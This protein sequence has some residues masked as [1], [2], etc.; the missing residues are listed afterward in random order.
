MEEKN[1]LNRKQLILIGIVILILVVI[2]ICF[3][4]ALK[5]TKSSTINSNSIGK[6]ASDISSKYSNIGYNSSTDIDEESI[7]KITDGGSYNLSGSYKNI[8]INTTKDV[9]LNLN[10]AEITCESGPAIYVENADTVSIVLIGKNIIT[11]YTTED[12][13]G[14]IYSKDDLLFSGTGS[15]EIK[16]N[17]DGIVS[18]DSL[19][20][21]SGTYIINSDDDGIRGKDNVAIVDGTFTITA[22]GDGIKSTNEKDSSKGYVAIDGGI[23]NITSVNDGIQA[24]TELV[25]KGGK[26]TIKTTNTS[27]QDSSKGLKAGNLV[28][29]NGGTFNLNTIDDGIHS[30]G[31]ITLNNGDATIISKDDGV[32]ADGLVEINNGTFDITA[33]EG[34]EGTYVKINGG[35]INISA[36]DDG[37]NAANKSNKYSVVVEISGGNIT[38]KMGTGDTDGI[39]SNGNLYINGGTINITCNS[40]F[41]YDGESKYTGGTIIVNGE[42]TNT[43]TNQMMGGGGPGGPGGRGGNQRP[44]R[45]Y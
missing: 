13:D 5:N 31:D 10:E 35:T 27:S 20:I 21:N 14:A 44:G 38:I 12:L 41:D 7:V 34:I 17:Y 24:E 28:E 9:E 23:F 6:S 2:V 45:R 26:F 42:E 36:S 11:S 19:V 1:K 4:I 29:I 32:H 33:V 39:D 16:S 15:L 43:I 8:T 25:I 18:K 40:P 3:M 22:G 30:N 37:I